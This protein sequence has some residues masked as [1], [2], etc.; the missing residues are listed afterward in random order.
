[1][2][3]CKRDF[4]REGSCVTHRSRW[5]DLENRCV[6]ASVIDAVITQHEWQVERYGADNRPMPD[7][8]GPKVEWLAPVVNLAQSAYTGRIDADAIEQVI[9]EEWDYDKESTDEERAAAVKSCT[10]LRVL[11]EEVVEA[12]ASDPNSE[13]LYGELIQVSAVALSWAADIKERREQ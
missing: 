5:L 2:R 10:R 7:G 4:T 13:A 12:A 6:A 8:T 9:R 1:M 11:R 3:P